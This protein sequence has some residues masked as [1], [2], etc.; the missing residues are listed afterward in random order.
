MIVTFKSTL[1]NI[2]KKF[3]LKIGMLFAKIPLTPNQWT[4]VS[5]IPAVA[6]F[7]FLT[8][9]NMPYALFAFI[10]AAMADAIDGGVAR[11][12]GQVTNFGAY[13]DGMT[14][15]FV[16]AALIFG[17][18]FYGYADWF[19]TGT[20]WLSMMLFFGTLMTAFSRAYADHRKAVTDP[21]ALA[22][23][24]G[25]LERAERMVLIFVSMA[26]TLVNPLYATYLIAVV[27]ALAVATVAQRMWFTYRFSKSLDA[28]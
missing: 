25:I 21:D 22:E 11:V 16:E 26:L 27:V 15:R 18:M 4:I 5:L 20:M 1:P 24:G 17:L 28:R 9:H 10:V 12:R 19:L 14:D 6:G 7:Y 13:L 2:T 3:S 8:Q 23:M